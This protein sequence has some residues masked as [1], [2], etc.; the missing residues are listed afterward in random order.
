MVLNPP[1][2]LWYANNNFLFEKY[3]KINNIIVS[4][5]KIEY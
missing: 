5:V 1:K 3:E 2:Q 4:G